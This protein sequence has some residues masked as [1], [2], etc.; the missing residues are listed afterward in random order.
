MEKYYLVNL[1]VLNIVVYFSYSESH[2]MELFL[3][4]TAHKA[5]GKERPGVFRFTS[6]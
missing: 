2:V 5:H 3:F 1:S 4:R 6:D